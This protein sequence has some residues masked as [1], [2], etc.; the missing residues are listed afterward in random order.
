MK[1]MDIMVKNHEAMLHAFEAEAAKA[2]DP[3]LKNFIA[4]V[5]PVVAHHL[6]MAK[7]IRQNEKTVG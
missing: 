7:A 2:T 1:Y 4:T 6:E 5:Q 3:K